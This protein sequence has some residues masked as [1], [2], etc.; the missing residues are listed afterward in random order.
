LHCNRPLPW[1]L[2]VVGAMVH[3]KKY[4]T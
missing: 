2:Q 3:L 4:F 1:R